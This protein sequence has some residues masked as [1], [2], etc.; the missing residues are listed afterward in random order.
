MRA[1]DLTPGMRVEITEIGY[2][3]RVY[4]EGGTVARVTTFT[5]SYGLPSTLVEFTDGHR[6][7]LVPTERVTVAVNP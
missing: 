4:A 2:G 5:D 3:G 7:E 1:R 6:M